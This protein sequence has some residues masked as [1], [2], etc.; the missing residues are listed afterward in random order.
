M[1]I[2]LFQLW[3]AGKLLCFV[4]RQIANID[5]RWQ[6]FTHLHICERY[7]IVSC[8]KHIVIQTIRRSHEYHQ[9]IDPEHV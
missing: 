8:E 9:I 2:S 1:Y 5:M 6:R 7:I 4:G 3:K